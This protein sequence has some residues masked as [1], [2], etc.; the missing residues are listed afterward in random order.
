MYVIV[1]GCGRVGGTLA[2]RLSR[3]GHEV[4]VIDHV[5][6][7][8]AHLDEGFLGR[9][10]EANPLAEDVLRNADIERAD[11]VAA[12]TNSDTVNAVVAHVARAIFRVPTVAA[13]NY[14]PDRLV[15]HDAFGLEAVSTTAW[16]SARFEEIVTAAD[17]PVRSAARPGRDSGK[18]A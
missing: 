3:A 5:G 12:V 8:F 4:T 17:R 18:G 2:M 14:D 13:R 11:A 15:L 7:S 16:G 6:S 9:T 10:V 1:V